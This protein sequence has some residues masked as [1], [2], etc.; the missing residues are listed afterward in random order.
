MQAQLVRWFWALVATLA[1]VSVALPTTAQESEP[2]ENKVATVNGAVITRADLDKEMARLRQQLFMM[3]Q[4]AT[5]S[6]MPEIEKDAF[7]NLVDFELLYQESKKKG[8]QVD[9]AALDERMNAMKERF[10]SE[11]EY[12]KAL[13]GMNVSEAALKSQF[14][15]GMAIEQLTITISAKAANLPTTGNT[16]DCPATGGGTVGPAGVELPVTGASIAR[17]PH[18]LWGALGLRAN[19]SPGTRTPE[20]GPLF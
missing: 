2:S 15:K 11:A 3:R 12:E 10:P 4:P 20:P 7:E 16:R 17:T 18:F 19:T 5:E 9:E 6:K 1:L 13:S 8:I 14:E